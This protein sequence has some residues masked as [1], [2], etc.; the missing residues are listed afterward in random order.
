MATFSFRSKAIKLLFFLIITLIG[1]ICPSNVSSQKEQKDDPTTLVFPTFLHTYG[2]RKATRFHLFLFTQNKAKFKN[3]QGLAVVRLK[4][5][6]DTTKT[7]DDDQVTV[8]GVNSGQDCIIFNS[9]MK[10]IGIYGLDEKGDE[11]LNH[12][13]GIAA[14]ENGEVYVADTGNH[15]IVKLFNPG[16][17]LLFQKSVGQKGSTTGNFIEP[18]GVALDS[19]GILYVTDNVNHRVQI[20]S[21]DLEFQDNWGESGNAPGQLSSPDGIAVID[22][23]ERWNYYREDFVVII[24]SNHSRIQ[25]FTL[26]GRY[27]RGISGSKFGFPNCYLAYIAMDYYNNIYVTDT[28]NHCIHKFDHYLNYLTSYGSYGTGDKAFVE[29]RGI[30]IYRRFGQVFVAEKG[31]AQYYWIGTDCFNFQ[32]K[33]QSSQTIFEF[34]YFLT[35]PSF[36]TTDILDEKNLLVTRLWT[37]QFRNTGWQKDYWGGRIWTIADSVFV[38]ENYKPSPL[39]QKLKTI[40][41]G[42]YFVRYKIEPTYSS[43]HY[44]KKIITSEFRKESKER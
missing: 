24:D 40:P 23:N 13:H 6:D 2:I 5:W 16:H 19:Q 4:S 10:S 44:F 25:Q 26:Q 12:P 3:P 29:P 30:T 1:C 39:Y 33:T 11:R 34:K 18:S 31:G 35:E 43:Y 41:D 28:K 15:R 21:A 14:N 22:K 38:R 9:S 36:V 42:K 8:Y 27:L 32:V 7:K 17:D 37:K 20:F